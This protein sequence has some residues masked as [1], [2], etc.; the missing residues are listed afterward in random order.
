MRRSAIWHSALAL[1][2]A[3]PALTSTSNAWA[4]DRAICYA[5]K[6]F[7]TTRVVLDVKKHSNLTTYGSKQT[8][9]GALGKHSYV[10]YSPYY[11]EY[12]AVV[13]G[14]VVVAKKSRGYPVKESGAHMGLISEWVRGPGYGNPNPIN[15]DCTSSE[16]SST[17]YSWSCSLLVDGKVQYGTLYQVYGDP[18]CG[19]F[20]DGSAHPPAPP[21]PPPP[22]PKPY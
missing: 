7:G 11:K 17:P 16:E 15:W 10:E 4:A 13:H 1:A 6:E 12:M 19:A 22:P 8:V 3:A 5:S 14:A 21:P 18:L 20:Q 2:V 9:Y